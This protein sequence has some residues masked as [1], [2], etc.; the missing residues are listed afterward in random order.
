M[1]DIWGRFKGG[2][3]IAA[4]ASALDLK[5]GTVLNHLRNAFNEGRPLRRDGLIEAS[6]LSPATRERVSRCFDELGVLRLKPIFDALDQQVP[7]DQLHL[8]RLIYQVT[9]GEETKTK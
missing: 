2:E 6:T 7:Y 9:P 4:I 1:D 3:S 5:Q 8:W